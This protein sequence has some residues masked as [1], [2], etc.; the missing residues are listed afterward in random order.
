LALINWGEL[1]KDKLQ[2]TKRNELSTTGYWDKRATS[3]NENMTNMQELTKTQ[4][5]VM[6]LTPQ[7]TV[8][9]VGAGTGRLTIPIAKRAKQ[10]TAVEPS[11][12]M[13]NLLEWNI[14]KENLQNVTP[15]NCSCEEFIADVNIQPYD[16]VVSSFSLFM[17]DIANALQKLDELSTKHVY[18]FLSASTWMSQ[19]LQRI[20]RGDAD[21]VNSGDYIYVYNILHDLGILANVEI[22]NFESNESYSNLDDA[23]TKFMEAYHVPLNKETGLREHLNQLLVKENGKLWLRNKRKA[24]MIWWTKN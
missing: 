21:S 20:V 16:V 24:A 13:Y 15:V 7:Y 10:V 14:K 5:N 11:K 12:K 17:V 19:T 6:Q 18:I 1:W 22:W 9:D 3:F 2:N 4:L 8:L 23:V